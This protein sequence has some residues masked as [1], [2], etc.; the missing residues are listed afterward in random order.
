MGSGVPLRNFAKVNRLLEAKVAETIIN[1][2]KTIQG[3]FREKQA[4]V[5]TLNEKIYDTCLLEEVDKETVEAEELSE[6][7][8]I[9]LV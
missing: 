6:M 8:F 3:V 1:S 4:G 5:K 2:S 7:I 9:L